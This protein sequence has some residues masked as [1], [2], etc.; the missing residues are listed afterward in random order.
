ME[1]QVDDFLDE[2]KFM[3][4]VEHLVKNKG[5]DHM[6][7][8]LEFCDENKLDVEEV[9]PLIGR[10]LKEKIRVDAMNNGMMKKQAQLPV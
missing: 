10:S 4:Q 8:V 3:M 2:Q 6:E 1:F 9:I 5:L 7:A